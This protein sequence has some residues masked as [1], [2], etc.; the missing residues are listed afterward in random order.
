MKPVRQISVLSGFAAKQFAVLTP[1]ITLAMVAVCAVQLSW[2]GWIVGLPPV[3]VAFEFVH[4]A[5]LPVSGG[6]A[7]LAVIAACFAA[8]ACFGGWCLAQPTRRFVFSHALA[9]AYRLLVSLAPSSWRPYNYTHAVVG[10]TATDG[11]FFFPSR[12]RR[13]APVA[14]TLSGAS[15][16]LE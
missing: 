11:L 2:M 4:E 5:A 7:L 9:W 8:I 6:I 12:R 14:A 10:L 15:P 13:T 3:E 1:I 16:L